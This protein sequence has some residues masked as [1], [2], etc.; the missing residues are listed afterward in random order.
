MSKEPQATLSTTS[1][2]SPET[3]AAAEQQDLLHTEEVVV[4]EMAIDGIC[5]VY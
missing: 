1:Q 2:E 3:D 5:G 4:E